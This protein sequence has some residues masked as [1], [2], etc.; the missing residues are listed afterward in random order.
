MGGGV[1]LCCD[2]LLEGG[3]T[4]LT[5][6]EVKILLLFRVPLHLAGEQVE[7]GRWSV[8]LGDRK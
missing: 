5:G 3:W 2:W 6:D 1:L 7:F 8:G 4:M